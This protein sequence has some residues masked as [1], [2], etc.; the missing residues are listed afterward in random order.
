MK[1][2]LLLACC[3]RRQHELRGQ[4]RR[5][6]SAADAKAFLDTVND[7]MKRLRIEQGRAG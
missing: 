3:L 4:Q 1:Q 6:P 7:T 2:A 5:S